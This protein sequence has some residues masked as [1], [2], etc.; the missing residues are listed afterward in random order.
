MW[1]ADNRLSFGLGP[2]LWYTFVARITL[3]R[4]DLSLANQRP[5][6]SSVM[7]APVP[8]TSAVSK[9]LMPFARA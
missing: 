9:K 5:M 3:S 2:V 1:T 6:I 4:R 8:Y 7:P